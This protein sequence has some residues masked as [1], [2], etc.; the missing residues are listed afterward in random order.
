M[1]QLENVEKRVP[2]GLVEGWFMSATGS[3]WHLV[4]TNCWVDQVGGLG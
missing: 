4:G 1:I 3:H 2:D